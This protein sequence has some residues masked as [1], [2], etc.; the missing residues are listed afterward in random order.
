MLFSICP[1]TCLHVCVVFLTCLLSVVG[2]SLYKQWKNIRTNQN[3]E[4]LT[5]K[6]NECH[7][8]HAYTK[9][10][11]LNYACSYKLM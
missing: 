8:K 11:Q 2:S 7:F 3:D 9:T 1:T 4:K 10:V 5:A 6:C